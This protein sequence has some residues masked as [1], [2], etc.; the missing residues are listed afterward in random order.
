LALKNESAG[1]PGA[2]RNSEYPKFTRLVDSR[3]GQR[4][5]KAI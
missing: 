1:E 3:Q 4:Q 5:Q 2:F